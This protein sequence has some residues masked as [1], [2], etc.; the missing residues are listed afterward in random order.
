M[1]Y[2]RWV[3]LKKFTSKN[4]KVTLPGF[5]HISKGVKGLTP[6]TWNMEGKFWKQGHSYSCIPPLLAC[7]RI[8][9]LH[10]SL[11]SNCQHAVS[12]WH[13]KVPCMHQMLLAIYLLQQEHVPR[14]SQDVLSQSVL[15]AMYVGIKKAGLLPLWHDKKVSSI[16]LSVCVSSQLKLKLL[17]RYR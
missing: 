7:Q 5:T 6:C 10:V 2:K 1:N 17:M 11:D 13:R 15:H 12:I 14:Q 16:Y 9:V 8:G 4:Y 3:Q